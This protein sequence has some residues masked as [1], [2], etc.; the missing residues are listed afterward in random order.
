[1][2]PSC[3]SFR[4]TNGDKPKDLKK[5]LGEAESC[6]TSQREKNIARALE[7]TKSLAAG[8]RGSK[9]TPPSLHSEA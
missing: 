1:V 4:C 7:S 8:W 6:F 2:E 5:A 3:Y 9:A